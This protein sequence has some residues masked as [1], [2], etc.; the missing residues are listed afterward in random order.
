MADIFVTDLAILQPVSTPVIPSS[1][2]GQPQ[3]LGFHGLSVFK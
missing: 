2:A 3:S 1:N